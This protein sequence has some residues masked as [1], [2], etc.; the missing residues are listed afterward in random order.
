MRQ[1]A[2]VGVGL[3][4]GSF[5]L[6]IRKA[7][8]TGRIVGVSSPATVQEALRLGVIDEGLPISKALPESDLV[9]LAQPIRRIIE[10]LS[11]LDP[12]LAP[13]ALVT[14]AGS[15][16]GE[17]VGRARAAVTRAQFLGGHP[18]AGKESRGVAAAEADLFR[19]RTYILT[20]SAPSELETPAAVEFRQWIE[21]I[22]SRVLILSP[23]EHDR[24][25]AFTSHLPQLLST[26]LAATLA[27][28]LTDEGYLLAGGPGLLDCTRLAMSSFEI[29][30]DILS[31][32]GAAIDSALAAFV[33]RLQELRRE[34]VSD[35]TRRS[36]EAGAALAARLRNGKR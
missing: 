31:T 8:Y 27:E 2:I 5:A 34:L 32:N 26:T 1:V 13:G 14:D 15:T 6:A 33:E 12:W 35:E 11:S 21:R 17:I 19:G 30:D 23:E 24:V 7:G 4:G 9:Y 28:R 20:P 22:G 16:K 29:W 3:I 36:F 25:V 18:M 10:D